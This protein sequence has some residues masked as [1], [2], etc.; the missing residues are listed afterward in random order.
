MHLMPKK[1][2]KR[3]T[4]KKPESK[5]KQSEQPEHAMNRIVHAFVSDRLVQSITLTVIS[6]ITSIICIALKMNT[7]KIA[8]IT[9][10][11]FLTLLIWVIGVRLIVSPNGSEPTLLFKVNTGILANDIPAFW[12][13]YRSSLGDTRSPMPIALYASVTNTKDFPVTLDRI[14][15]KARLNGAKWVKFL[16]VPTNAGD[17]CWMYGGSLKDVGLLDLTTNCLDQLLDDKPIGGHSTVRG[18][19]FFDT[20]TP[21]ITTEGDTITYKW[22]AD[23]STGEKYEMT[24]ES[25]IRTHVEASQDAELAGSKLIFAKAHQD[26]SNAGIQTKRWNEVVVAAPKK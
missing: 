6:L 8:V 17:A 3:N 18:W 25:P 12:L 14:S 9:A 22:N 21:F 4:K 15:V 19:I 20:E 11:V 13:R 16:H 10:C 7:F 23:D 5:A 26:L 2:R 1:N 24:T